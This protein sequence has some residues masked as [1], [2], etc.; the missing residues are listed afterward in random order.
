MLP[1]RLLVD[2]RVV[3]KAGFPDTV[4]VYRV[5]L[6]VSAEWFP[7]EDDKGAARRPGR[8]EVDDVVPGEWSMVGAVRVHLVDLAVADGDHDA[9]QLENANCFESGDQLG[10]SSDALECLKI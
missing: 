10:C 8:V 1:V 2:C 9:Q 6:R 7:G 4:C 3:G 5:E